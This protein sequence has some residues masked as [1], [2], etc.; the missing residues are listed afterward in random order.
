MMTLAW[1][2]CLLTAWVSTIA[3]AQRSW[4]RRRETKPFD[5][6]AVLFG[7]TAFVFLALVLVLVA[8]EDAPATLS[9][10]ALPTTATAGDAE[11]VTTTCQLFG[12]PEGR[13]DLPAGTDQ[14]PCLN[15][16]ASRLT[17]STIDALVITGHVDK[18]ELSRNARGIYGS[19][20]SLALQ[21]A[22]AVRGW[23]E[24]QQA[25]RVKRAGSANNGDLG[26]LAMTVA[27]G[28]THVG[29]DVSDDERKAD[30]SVEIRTVWKVRPPAAATKEPLW[31]QRIGWQL[32]TARLDAGSALTFLAF[33]VALSAYLATVRLFL[34]GLA[35][36]SDTREG[37]LR[38][39]PASKK[40]ALVLITLADLPMILAGLCMGLYL[41]AFVPPLFFR[42]SLVLFAFGGGT[43]IIL[44]AREWRKSV[45]EVRESIR[46]EEMHRRSSS[47][48]STQKWTLIEP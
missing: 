26:S 4:T 25:S 11:T 19:N 23:L 37:G 35:E 33:V 18:Q 15:E 9:E 14:T 47:T 5:G 36:P 38:L 40:V 2:G 45:H 39:R 44:H 17:E 24:R 46:A 29:A 42:W 13:H 3:F 34:H 48:S 43:M 8:L 1:V 30:R 12:F 22:L 16:L 20:L 10:A 41:F 7:V 28:A 32:N 27:S 6:R 21:R 31:W